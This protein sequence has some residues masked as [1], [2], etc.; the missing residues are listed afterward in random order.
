MS[1]IKQR[2]NE[3]DAALALYRNIGKKTEET[4]TST[5]ATP[6]EKKVFN[7]TLDSEDLFAFN[8]SG[9]AVY[10]VSELKPKSEIED[11]FFNLFGQLF[12]DLSKVEFVPVVAQN[13]KI[14]NAF[15]NLYF[16]FI[17]DS[18]WDEHNGPGVRALL[19][20]GIEIKK[21]SGAAERFL[22]TQ[23]V[24]SINTMDA[25]R[26]AKWSEEASGYFDKYLH[27]NKL[28]DKVKDR[29]LNK[30]NSSIEIMRTMS[31]INGAGND[32]IGGKIILSFAKLC[33][34]IFCKPEEYGKYIFDLELTSTSN[35]GNDCLFEIKK[36]SKKKV[37]EYK[38][39]GI[40]LY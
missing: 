37:N 8:T 28:P 22:A 17:P 32:N 11:Y 34:L 23:A 29:T 38:K 2:I 35:F 40:E 18:A 31:Y 13:N 33:D 39:K 5:E 14:V 25:T 27:F 7:I 16:K 6:E 21:S 10:A 15:V 30:E 4:A 26:Y 19:N 24:A 36:V 3:K 20:R 12:S 1:T 9:A